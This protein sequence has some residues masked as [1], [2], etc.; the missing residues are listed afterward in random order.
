MDMRRRLVVVIAGA[1]AAAVVVVGIG[2]LVLTTI[3]ARRQNQQDLEDRIVEMADVLSLTGTPRAERVTRRLQPALGVDTIGLIR[4]DLSSPLLSDDEMARLR[5]GEAVSGRHGDV[6][7]AAAPIPTLAGG[8]PNRALVATDT[9]DAG[10]GPPTRWFLLASV[11]TVVIGGL[12]AM[13]LARRLTGPLADAEA[14]ARRIAQG[15]LSARID[16]PHDPDD[17]LGRLVGSINAMAASLQSAQGLERDFLLSVSHDLRTPL[18]S[19]SGWAEA[20]A[21]G[22]A[23]DPAKAGDTILSEAGR[24]DRLVRDLLDLARLRARSFRLDLRPVDLRDA[25]AGAAEGLRPDLED[26]DL[27]VRVDMT[28]QPVVVLG[29]P[30]R[31]AQ[32]AANLI[33][34]AGRYATRQVRISVEIDPLGV[35]GGAAVLAVEDDGQGIPPDERPHLFE[36]MYAGARPAARTGGGTGLG[37]TIVRELAQAMGGDVSVAEGGDGGARFEVQLPLAPA[38]APT[39]A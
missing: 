24:L 25:A 33:E 30:D 21:D 16:A 4:L 32:V 22:T 35:A 14:T 9:V 15:D 36:R 8:P 2:T 5:T 13:R 1:V 19:I 28:H 37:L 18:T 7:H 20:L 11:V 17:E 12:V 31:L 34:N 23:P 10:L 27:R 3:D 38:T 29:D 39:S 26:D 6:A